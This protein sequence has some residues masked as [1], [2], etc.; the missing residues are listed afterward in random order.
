MSFHTYHT[1][2]TSTTIHGSIRAT[3]IRSRICQCLPCFLT[4]ND[5]TWLPILRSLIPSNRYFQICEPPSLASQDATT[6][7]FPVLFSDHAAI[8]FLCGSPSVDSHGIYAFLSL[9]LWREMER[10]SF[11]SREGLRL[12]TRTG[13]RPS[14]LPRLAPV[15][16]R[17]MRKEHIHY[18]GSVGKYLHS[19]LK[20]RVRY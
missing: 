18:S 17:W 9:Q 10:N 2:Y 12:G 13:V 15:K 14:C 16:P 20:V 8:F 11:S 7:L 1:M 3:N 6:A 4:T 19:M 5:C